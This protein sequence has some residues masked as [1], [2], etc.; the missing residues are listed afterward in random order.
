MNKDM[1]IKMKET[2]DC[3]LKIS[4]LLMPA[5]LLDPKGAKQMG[6][7]IEDM[8]YLNKNYYEINEFLKKELENNG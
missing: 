3:A 4:A 7:T 2:F 1:A 8:L 5:I 6:V